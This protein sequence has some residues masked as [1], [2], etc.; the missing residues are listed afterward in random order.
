VT[1]ADRGEGAVSVVDLA[2]QFAVRVGD[3]RPAVAVGAA[4]LGADVRAVAGGDWFW[5]EFI[6]VVHGVS[7][8]DVEER[9]KYYVSLRAGLDKLLKLW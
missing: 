3:L 7:I 5:T 9:S 6:Y 2:V 4:V 1:G 8:T